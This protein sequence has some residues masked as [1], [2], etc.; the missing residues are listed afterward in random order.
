[1]IHNFPSMGGTIP[2]AGEALS[3]I[4]RSLGHAFAG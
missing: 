4:A 2:K 1:M 3:L